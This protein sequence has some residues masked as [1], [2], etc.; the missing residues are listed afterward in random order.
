MPLKQALAPDIVSVGAT[1]LVLNALSF[2]VKDMF[3]SEDFVL[4]W[5]L[6]F[7][8]HSRLGVEE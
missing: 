3:M 4:H 6:F 2:A 1:R 7:H 8:A 5:L